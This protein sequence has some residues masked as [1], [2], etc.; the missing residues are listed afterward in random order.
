MSKMAVVF[1]E[2]RGGG[3]VVREKREIYLGVYKNLGAYLCC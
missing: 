3:L 2:S 1:C